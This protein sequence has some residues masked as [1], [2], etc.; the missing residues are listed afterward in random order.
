MGPMSLQLLAQPPET[1]I[2]VPDASQYLL[3]SSWFPLQD[4]L[5]SFVVLVSHC[6]C[7][8]SQ[9]LPVTDAKLD[10]RMRDHELDKDSVL[11]DNGHVDWG[12]SFCIL[13]RDSL[14]SVM[15]NKLNV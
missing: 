15:Q 6:T 3:S 5:C 10:V 9:A 8:R 12:S 13:R 1:T 4:C 11:I 7:K 14:R 2:V